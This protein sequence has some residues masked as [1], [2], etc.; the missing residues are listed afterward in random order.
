LRRGRVTGGT[1]EAA[2]DDRIVWT[3][4]R[5]PGLYQAELLVEHGPDGFAFDTLVLEV[6]EDTSA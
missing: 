1:F 2:L 4:P 3:L 5:Q 6:C